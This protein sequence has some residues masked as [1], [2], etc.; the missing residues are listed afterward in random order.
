MKKIMNISLFI[1][2]IGLIGFI[3]YTKFFSFKS[4]LIMLKNQNYESILS[5]N[6][7]VIIKKHANIK[8][9][10][11]QKY[12]DFIKNYDESDKIVTMET[13]LN[14]NMKNI[15][16]QDKTNN[17]EITLT[18][19][20]EGVKWK[21]SLNLEKSYEILE[22]RSKIKNIEDSPVRSIDDLNE[23]IILYTDLGIKEQINY[24]EKITLY[25]KI[26]QDDMDK[27]E[28]LANIKINVVQIKQN[29]IL[30]EITNFSKN[31]ISNVKGN[32][33]I[34]DDNKS[35]YKKDLILYELSPNNFIYSQPIM[36]NYKKK[37]GF[38][39]KDFKLLPKYKII[40]QIN[41]AK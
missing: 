14:S 8:D 1:I 13:S 4:T 35:I 15:R 19:I 6:D 41:E 30:A 22:L 28:L 25:K 2:I 31:M 16:I 20:L 36:P 12:I 38:T 10:L 29:T 34:L 23:L 11:D 7:L 32:L 3:I 17:T 9:L 5:T 24:D 21:I 33:E 40:F 18:E 26:I 37:V 39:L 27:K